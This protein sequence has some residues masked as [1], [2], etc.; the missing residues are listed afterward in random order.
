MDSFRRPNDET[1]AIGRR[2]V[3]LE[4]RPSDRQDVGTLFII[5]LFIL[6]C[7]VYA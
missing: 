6:S 7:L 1:P 3:S 5:L 4:G 2:S